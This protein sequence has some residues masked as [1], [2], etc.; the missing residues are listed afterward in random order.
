MRKRVKLVVLEMVLLFIY[1]KDADLFILYF[2]YLT[3]TQPSFKLNYEKKPE[4]E[5]NPN[6]FKFKVGI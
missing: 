1:C 4:S 2:S 3:L 6:W 5:W